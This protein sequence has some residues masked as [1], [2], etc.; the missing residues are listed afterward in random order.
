MNSDGSSQTQLTFPTDPNA[1]DANVPAWSRDGSKI[2]FFGGFEGEYGNI[3]TMNAD[4]SGRTQLTSETG[5]NS[6]DNPAW[7]PDGKYILFQSNRDGPIET[8][9]MNADGTGRVVLSSDSF[10]SSRLPVIARNE[11][12]IGAAG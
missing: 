2:V 9:I 5:T 8:W 12:I 11:T 6:S 1:P 10:F 3:Y 4:G 7:S